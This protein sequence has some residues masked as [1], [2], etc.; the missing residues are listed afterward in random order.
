MTAFSEAFRVEVQRMA[1]KGIK[2]ELDSLRKTVAAQRTEI[3]TLK[4]DVKALAGQV[5]A[6]QKSAGKQASARL[7]KDAT[8]RPVEPAEAIM[9]RTRRGTFGPSDLARK[10]EQLGLTQEAM[11]QLLEA[12]ALTVRRWEKGKMTPRA[13][14][15]E[16][17]H[18]VRKLGKRAALTKLKGEG[19]AGQSQSSSVGSLAKFSP[20]SGS[21]E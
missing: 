4:R 3:A 6:L 16:R 10:R 15:L 17:I 18:A 13:A 20:E 21:K 7:G 11:A 2:G 9:V 1:R 19:Y 8:S 14:Q 12:S 5:K